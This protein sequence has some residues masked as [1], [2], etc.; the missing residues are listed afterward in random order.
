M[1]T[2]LEPVITDVQVPL[3]QERAF[4]LFTDDI[5]SWWPLET[6]AVHGDAD[7]T[8]VVE[9]RVGGRI[10]ELTPAG[11]E[12]DWGRITDWEPPGRVAFTWHPGREDDTATRVEVTFAATADGTEVR[13][14]H[15]GWEVLGDRAPAVR[16]RYVTGWAMVLGQ[17]YAAAARADA[18]R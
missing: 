4:R 1:T 10:Y 18:A 8:C 9:G 13:L 7:M 14:V 5:A 3:D 15:T 12:A 17:R 11:V 6:H 2:D 16:E